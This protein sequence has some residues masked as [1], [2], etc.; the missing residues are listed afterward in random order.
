MRGRA[1]SQ[2]NVKSDLLRSSHHPCRNLTVRHAAQTRTD[3][4]S[5]IFCAGRCSP[6]RFPYLVFH[7]FFG[8]R[9]HAASSEQEQRSRWAHVA[10]I[11]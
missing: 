8:F 4:I 3:T 5:E 1:R 2:K 9:L 7:F 10:R 6:L 11:R